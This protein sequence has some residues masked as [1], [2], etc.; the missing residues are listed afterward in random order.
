VAA[1][2]MTVRNLGISAEIYN[3]WRYFTACL[4][5]HAVISF[6]VFHGKRDF[7]IALSTYTF[8]GRSVLNAPWVVKN[9]LPLTF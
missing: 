4:I 7:M 9:N 6:T 1:L 8:L 2:H 5:H 3:Q